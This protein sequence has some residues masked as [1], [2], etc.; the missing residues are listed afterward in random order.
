MKQLVL[1][2]LVLG[3]AAAAFVWSRYRGSVEVSPYDL[4]DRSL[5][6]NATE[7]R[8]INGTVVQLGGLRAIVR[9][10]VGTNAWF[11]YWGG[12]T[13]TY[14]KESLDTIAALELPES[15][16]VLVVAPPGYD[17]SEGHPDPENVPRA[18]IA[19]RDWLVNTKH[20]TAIVMGGFSMGALSAIVAA[21]PP[22]TKGI[23][24]LA[25]FTFFD[26]GDPSRFIRLKVPVRYV[27]PLD[28]PPP[29]VKAL[30]LHGEEDD[31]FLPQMGKDVAKWL[32]ADFA[33]IPGCGHVAIQTHPLAI[34]RA[35][36]FIVERL[37]SS[38]AETP[39]ATSP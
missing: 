4:A 10:P 26:T 39:P 1:V 8:R 38:P 27:P 25:S 29:A 22:I 28:Q 16:G 15:I 32:H 20:A 7:A 9:E 33:P 12:N 17:G 11:L 18:A 36:K 31:G 14:F 13:S 5:E 2:V 6:E 24:L 3:A 30:V 21:S 23:V 34:K 19:A 35:R 37:E